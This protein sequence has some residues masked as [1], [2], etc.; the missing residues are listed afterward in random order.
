MSFSASDVKKLREMTGAGMMA[1]KKALSENN[2]D[3]DSAVDF[4]RKKGLAAAQKKQ[5]RIAAEGAV[6]TMVE[7][8][9]GVVV[10]V[11]CE[12]DFVSKGDDFKGFANEI[13]NYILKESPADITALKAAKETE[14]NELTLKIGEKIDIRRFELVKSEGAIGSYNHGGRIGVLVD[15][16]GADASNEKVQELLKDLSMHV[17]AAGP[18]FLSSDDLNHQRRKM[19]LY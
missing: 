13:A 7:G 11:N 18:K 6:A 15:V 19:L 4:L 10:E 8:T 16:K 2:G 1:C 5:S 14:V 17:A 3:M 9:N 12:T